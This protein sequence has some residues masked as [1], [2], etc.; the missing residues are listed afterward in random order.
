MT[1][2]RRNVH[3]LKQGMK[4][5]LR[6]VFYKI[7]PNYRNILKI[8][9]RL[10]DFESTMNRIDQ[11]CSMVIENNRNQNMF[12]RLCMASEPFVYRYLYLLRYISEN[13]MVLDLECEYGTGAD[14]L[15]KYTAINQ[16]CCLNTVDYYTRLGKMY[17]GSDSLIFQ[18]GCYRDI[19]QKYNIVICFHDRKNML[20][21]KEDIHE[22]CSLIEYNGILAISF[23]GDSG[24]SGSLMQHAQDYGLVLEN[25]FY[26]CDNNPELA[27]DRTEYVSSIIMYLRKND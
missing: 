11:K 6:K 16:C 8:N 17:Y 23:H 5:K 7:N 4:D 22:L 10:N 12:E 26:Q 3:E 19:V 20:L 13:D 25:C 9:D 27:E 2:R 18:T 14:L 24:L 15:V 21:T 1:I